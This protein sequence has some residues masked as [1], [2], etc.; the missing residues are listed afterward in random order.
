MQT[1]IDSY[2][3]KHLST[4]E[5]LNNSTF[6]LP[7]RRA[8]GFFKRSL[9][10]HFQHSFFMPKMYSIEDFIEEIAAVEII[11]SLP[12]SFAFFEVYQDLTHPNKQE[13]FEVVYNWSQSLLAD[14]NEIDRF[15]ID[16]TQFFSNLKAI[17]EIER[18]GGENATELVKN[19]YEFWDQ[20]PNYYHA[21]KENL[22]Q[23]NQAY[24][25]MAYQIALQKFPAYLKDHPAH[26]HFIGFNALNQCE[27][28]I[29]KL[30]LKENQASVFWDIDQ[31]FWNNKD[32]SVQQFM[33]EYQNS[34]LDQLNLKITPS[35]E[36]FE[37]E[38][39]IQLTATPRKIGQVK[40]VG[41][42]LSEFSKAELQETAIV[43]ADE[44]LLQPLLNAIPDHIQEVNITMGQ[45]LAQTPLAS[46]FEI[47]L[48]IHQQNLSQLFYQDVLQL[49]SHPIL[50]QAFI[51][52]FQPIESHF[53]KE[54]ILVI[55]AE[56]LMQIS[57]HSSSAYQEIIQILFSNLNDS[58]SKFL[59]MATQVCVFLKSFQQENKLQ[60][61]YLFSFYSLFQK[62][63]NFT[64]EFNYIE[65][66]GGLKQIYQDV[67]Q[68]E[69]LDF[70]GYPD[71]GLQI[72]G[73]LETRVLDFKN[74]I[75]IGVNEGVL[76][77]GKSQNSFI[78]FDLK[79]SYQLPTYKE[80]DAIY[81]YHFF[82]LLQR[83]K[84]IYVT[85][86]NDS[87]GMEKSEASRFLRQLEI[88]APKS[89]QITH[90]IVGMP[91]QTSQKSLQE[92]KKTPAMIQ[93]IKN[94]LAYGI[95]PSALTTYIRNPID[96]YQ[97]YLLKIR[98]AEEIEEEVS[99]RVYGNV[100]HQTLENLY[101]N[102]TGKIIT[103]EAVKK[104]KK[105]LE[106]ELF[107]QF[108]E[109][110]NQDAMLKG[111]NLLSLEIAKNQC[112]RFLNSELQLVEKHEVQLVSLEQELKI[113]FP[114]E[115][116]D[117]PI[118]LKGTADR[119][120]RVDGM[121]RI[122]DYKT[123][124]VSQT[125]LN[126][127]D[128]A[129]LTED[130]KK[131]KAFQVLFYSL[132]LENQLKGELQSGIISF[133]NLSAGFMKFQ[134]KEGR[135]TITNVIDENVKSHFKSCLKSLICEILNPEIPFIEKEV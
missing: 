31:F 126:I 89:H 2:I 116:M 96:F 34:W 61:A 102:L 75:I 27:Q 48:K 130:F 127:N 129:L 37:D 121:Y 108:Q 23:K 58:P 133:K 35:S 38:K 55:S 112:Q 114:I 13:S 1:F 120:D 15:N 88:Y 97:K 56:E 51:K 46:F 115:G 93:E 36:S 47:L 20:L 113:K 32:F 26:I 42:I 74:L 14:F 104:M 3:E 33:Q 82:R 67:L 10:K 122:I 7:S 54:N 40:Y 87:A 83:A 30:A 45:A 101:Q 57:K 49:L 12:T 99:Y 9:L 18:F 43:L 124:K 90:Q 117:Y 19:Y 128:Y 110:F 125:D 29:F 107:I 64:E 62:L 98:E 65:N 131:A 4:A 81:A 91:A 50:K 60:L 73:V 6:V 11:N 92:I 105:G 17:K 94:L 100:V 78:P 77:A 8:I 70:K 24:Q 41:Q 22:N 80:K 84:N 71:R 69:T 16:A 86:N 106:E 109:Q 79:I 59:A 44:N 53:K 72:M 5:E 39:H 132:L 103:A 21:L 76:P 95:S 28:Q 119:V 134:L 135:K 85:Y 66:I 118:H 68:S 25:G 123:G 52:D 63:I 111:K